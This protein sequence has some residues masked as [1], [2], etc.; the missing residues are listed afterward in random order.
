MAFSR[1]DGF[2]ML[3][4]NFGQLAAVSVPMENNAFHVS[5]IAFKFLHG[6]FCTD[7]NIGIFF[8][9]GISHLVNY[10]L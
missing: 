8:N 6:I 3:V 7:L 2:L 10:H 5:A 1:L 9:A 4:F